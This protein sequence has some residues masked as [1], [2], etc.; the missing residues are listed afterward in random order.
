VQL[1][2]GIS[3]FMVKKIFYII[4][5]VLL[6]PVGSL[7]TNAQ[8]PAAYEVASMP[9]NQG[10]FSDISPVIVK[11]GIMFCSNRRFSVVTDRTAF[12]GRRLYNI[13]FVA[14]KDSIEWE[15]PVEL[16]S[17]RSTLF[18]NG[19]LCLAADKK[20][21]YFTTEVETGIATRKK[22]FINHSGIFTAELSGTNLNSIKPFK[23]NNTQY[24]V[25]QPSISSDGK[26]LFFASDMP[27]GHGKSDLWYCEFINGEWSTPVNLGPKVNSPETDNFPNMHPSGRLYFSSDRPGG[28]GK[29]DVYFTSLYYG[30]WDDPTLLPE[31]INSPSDD[32]AF[33]AEEDL[34][35][36]YFV[37]N[38]RTDDDIFRFASKI[39]RKASCDTLIE[40]NYC[41]RFLEENAVKADTMP[42][43]YEWKFSDGTK[44]EGAVV[45]HCFKGPGKYFFQLDVVN[46]I[47]KE[48][49]YNEK[50]DTLFIQDAIQP[51][52][53]GPDRINTGQQIILNADSTNLP[54]W[55]ISRYYWN[56]GDETVGQGIEV[57]KKYLKPG[58]YNI[59]LI[60]TEEPQP[61]G[62]VREAC[63]SKNI[64]VIR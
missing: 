55:K 4:A 12:D 2:P 64:I 21:V 39:V 17:E 14:K 47:T 29:L 48:I 10:S 30:E 19:P 63:V 41:Y 44:A 28:I 43:R 62:I 36:G 1:I 8:Q 11:D 52:I 35:T 13:Y 23:Y 24:D 56:F 57:P 51:Y 38:R 25:G 34:Q 46:L 5:V 22:N 40:N 31:P 45:D 61:G 6:I 9:F 27:G 54:G 15:K 42:F 20:T 53:S 26:Y 18:N 59:Q 58:K 37:S 7:K 32:F 50:T 49:I 16:I 33:V 3:R 60:V